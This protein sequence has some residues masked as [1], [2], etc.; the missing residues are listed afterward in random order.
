MTADALQLLLDKDEIRELVSLYVHRMLVADWQGMAALF[1][2]DGVLDYAQALAFVRLARAARERDPDTTLVFR[3]RAEIA[4]YLP[5]TEQLHVRA[6]FT[7]HVISVTGDTAVCLS[8]FDNRLIQRGESVV[9][10]GRMSDELRRVGGRWLFAYRRQ[11][12]F[13]MTGL[14]QGWADG[15]DRTHPAPLTSARGWEAELIRNGRS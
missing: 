1:T 11:E 8:T 14:A 3:G 2:E 7:N 15:A 10:A 4:A 6:F 12:L 5:I 9:G 13:F